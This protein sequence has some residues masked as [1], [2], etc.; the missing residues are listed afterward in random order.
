MQVFAPCSNP[1]FVVARL[2]SGREP[3]LKSLGE[4]ERDTDKRAVFPCALMEIRL[5]EA[6][7]IFDLDIVHFPSEGLVRAHTVYADLG[8]VLSCVDDILLPCLKGGIV[9]FCSL[10]VK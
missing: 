6:A 9:R 2:V 10:A 8:A 3:V 5:N 1:V 4:R 7:L